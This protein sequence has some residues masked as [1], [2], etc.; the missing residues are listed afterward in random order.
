MNNLKNNVLTHSLCFNSNEDMSNK[1]KKINK[2]LNTD[3]S[4]LLNNVDVNLQN[5]MVET[6]LFYVDNYSLVYAK[7]ILQ[8]LIYSFKYNLPSE[9]NKYFI[10]S[11]YA[12]IDE[13]NHSYFLST[14]CFLKKWYE[15]CLPGVDSEAYSYICEIRAKGKSA[16][17]VVASMDPVKGPF[18]ESEIRGIAQKSKFAVKNNTLDN[19]I[20]LIIMLLIT[21][22]RRISQILN[23]RVRDLGGYSENEY[24]NVPRAK[25]R[26]HSR[27]L[28]REIKIESELWSQLVSLKD[29]NLKFL[30]GISF[31]NNDISGY[32]N[33]PI[34][35]NK[36]IKN[37]VKEII[38]VRDMALN[39]SQV[40][41]ALRKFVEDNNV[42]SERTNQLIKMNPNRFRYTF[43]TK[44]A[45]QGAS[46][47]EIAYA[48][49]HSS[50]ACAGVYIKN[51]PGRVEAIDKAVTP[52]LKDIADIFM[53][54]R[55]YN[56]NV[57]VSSIMPESVKNIRSDGTT[58]SCEGC[59]RL[60]KWR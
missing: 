37:K 36:K 6:L 19:Q 48:L 21:T 15:L 4:R 28:F 54:K 26:A 20:Y 33:I 10:W 56:G 27:D 53:G 41:Y 59:K 17:E 23:L 12:N 43:G 25:Q 29:E 9:I 13:K 14:K 24:L 11:L 39:K 57:L 60:K 35:L 40:N 16:G 30:K 52:Y 46:I 44:L 1:I 51:E 5:S 32:D 18:T 38:S 2:L 47:H 55:S 45:Q 42:L 34:F 3:I 50:T 58:P 31:I 49:D 7:N 22:G 8:G